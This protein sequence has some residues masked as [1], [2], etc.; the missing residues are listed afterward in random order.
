[1]RR[2]RA[3]GIA[4]SASSLRSFRVVIFGIAFPPRREFSLRHPPL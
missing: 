2:G 1:M 4:E 3:G